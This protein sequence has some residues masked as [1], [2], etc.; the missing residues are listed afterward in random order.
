[1][2]DEIM[3][4]LD[5]G[6]SSES[7]SDSIK[8]PLKDCET[9]SLSHQMV[10]IASPISNE[11]S[12]SSSDLPLSLF[13]SKKRTQL[14]ILSED[15]TE[16]STSNTT[17][18]HHKEPSNV[19]VLMDENSSSSDIPL[20]K[21]AS[22]K[23]LVVSKLEVPSSNV[24]VSADDNS[25]SSD[26]P[27]AKFVCSSIQHTNLE[28][29]KAKDQLRKKVTVNKSKKNKSKLEVKLEDSNASPASGP[30]SL[31][32][33]E[34]SDSNSS[35]TQARETHKSNIKKN[36]LIK[37]KKVNEKNSLKRKRSEETGS[38]QKRVKT[39]KKKIFRLIAAPTMLLNQ[40]VSHQNRLP[41]KKM[42]VQQP[43]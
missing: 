13:V 5:S 41:V 3:E 29:K 20:S 14:A 39:K 32:E 12:N 9:L 30:T 1:M 35:F 7:E 23:K 2:S 34:D 40:K 18:K 6:T 25:C 10:K 31:V 36:K 17:E 15:E 22:N 42:A 21:L 37:T 8:S 4:A 24:S 27:L 33:Q 28:A 38:E 26:V 11:N 16:S 43:S 19:L